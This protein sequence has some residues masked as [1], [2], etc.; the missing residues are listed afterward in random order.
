MYYGNIDNRVIKDA[1]E[2]GVH[3]IS[4]NFVFLELRRITGFEVVFQTFDLNIK[5]VSNRCVLTSWT[6]CTQ[7]WWLILKNGNWKSPKTS[8]N[9]T[10]AQFSGRP[11]KFLYRLQKINVSN[12]SRI[13]KHTENVHESGKNSVLTWPFRAKIADQK[14]RK[15]KKGY[16]SDSSCSLFSS[17]QQG[18]QLLFEHH[19]RFSPTGG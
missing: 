9:T 5:T 15:I 18:E 19:R 16:R 4:R 11:E 13:E 10:F 8:K 3:A 2:A 7:G 14:I 17:S 6:R 12:R 1:E